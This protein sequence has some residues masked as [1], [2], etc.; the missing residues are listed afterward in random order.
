[1]VKIS[2]HLLALAR[3]ASRQRVSVILIASGLGLILTGCALKT[4][5]QPRHEI[6]PL[7]SAGSPEFRHSAGS[8]LG[9]DFVS[10]NNI[11]TL[12]NGMQIFP[13]ML[14]AIRS[15]KHTINFETYVFNDGRIGREFS[16]ALAERARAGV[17]VC[18]ILDAQGT[19]EMGSGNLSQMRGAGVDVVKYHSIVWLDPRRF[20]NRTHR[21][22]LIVDGKTAFVGGVGIADE[23]A[24]NADSPQHWRDNHYKVTGPVVAQV[25]GIFTAHWLATR[26]N[27]LHGADY[28]PPLAGTGPYLAQAI[29]SSTGNANL[30]LMYLLAI[31]SARN[32][33]RIENAYFLPSDLARKELIHAA[34]RGVRVEIIVPGKLID[35]KLVRASSKRHWPELLRAG[36]K[37]YEYQP[38]M[39]HVKLMVV[40]G[41]FV[42][43]GS[44]NFDH[45]SISLNDEA[46]LDVLD[47]GF[48]A[49]QTRL[50]DKDKRRSRL[51]RLDEVS[52][53][54]LGD[55]FQQAAGAVDSQL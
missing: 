22:L 31:A 5:K 48:A 21:K 16:D 26:G 25:Q 8:L 9:A 3:V 36:V 33:L 4:G 19:D 53:V 32:S 6:T 23:W 51:I 39:M 1:M 44:G 35:E 34:E 42:S 14:S 13:S 43:V 24:G 29:R 40:D 2:T 12:A 18:A 55:L 46:N 7:Y 37:I 11:T 49:E 10:G 45:R 50:F 28:F 27:V 30:D 47:R 15:A 52:H 17:K 41:V 38:T 20:N 54:A